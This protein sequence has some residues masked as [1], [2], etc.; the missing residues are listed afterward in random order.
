MDSILISV[1]GV[2]I[3]AILNALFNRARIYFSYSRGLRE[4]LNR[5]WLTWWETKAIANSYPSEIKEEV[6]IKTR[7]WLGTIKV[8]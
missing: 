2:I 4:C 5:T 8:I 1:I 7:I 6:I 3:G